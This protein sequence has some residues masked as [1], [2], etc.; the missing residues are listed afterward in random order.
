MDAEEYSAKR[1]DDRSVDYSQIHFK[2]KLDH[3]SIQ[4]GALAIFVPL[5][6]IF[7]AA[8][9]LLWL[10]HDNYGPRL[11][12]TIALILTTVAL[13]YALADEI[14]SLRY[15]T[16]TDLLMIEV[17]VLILVSLVLSVTHLWLY[18]ERSQLVADRFNRNVRVFYP[19]GSASLV[20]VSIFVFSL[21][22]KV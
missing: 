11:E 19:I 16:M 14:P 7:I 9:A 18:E 3:E 13:K 4:A 5:F 10:D 6:V 2:V 21:I 1:S 15:M 20:A 12:G 17:I 8:S 22:S